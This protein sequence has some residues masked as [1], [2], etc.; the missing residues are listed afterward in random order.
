[1]KKDEIELNEDEIEIILLCFKNYKR[2]VT[3]N[4]KQL[5]KF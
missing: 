3:F 4:E 5:K 1:M 2:K